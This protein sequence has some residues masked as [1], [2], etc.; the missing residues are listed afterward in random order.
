MTQLKVQG[1]FYP[2]QHEEWLRACRELTPAQRDVLYF[3]R[4]LDPY[5]NGVELSAA[6]IARQL[7]APERKVHRQTVSRAL[8]E[9][10]VKRFIELELLTV[11]VTVKP[12]GYWCDE[13]PGCDETP[14]VPGDTAVD[15]H[16]PRAIATHHPEPEP[17][18]GKQS[19]T[20]K[21][22]LDFIKTLSDGER[23]DFLKF[24]EAEAARLPKPPVLLSRWVER[25]SEELWAKFKASASKAGLEN[26][27]KHPQR[28]EW[29]D[30]IRTL[31]FGS[32]IYE[33]GDRDEERYQFYK[34]ADGQN[35][36]WGQES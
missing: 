22:Y 20:S 30:K 1:K 11:K 25:N 31:G 33:S 17:P 21:T 35:L 2:L 27:G 23:E 36:I 19:C 24:A 12:K 13:T 8:K 32:F 7:S 4:T 14:L 34:W 29:L 18:S 10:D 28:E 3:I 5:G 6:E 16:A 26:W 15:H 9:L